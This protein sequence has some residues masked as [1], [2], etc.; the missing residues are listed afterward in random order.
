[1]GKS[2]YHLG[3]R[4]EAISLTTCRLT[5]TGGSISGDRTLCRHGPFNKRTFF[6]QVLPV[7]S[8][9]TRPHDIRQLKR[10][11]FNKPVPR[12]FNGSGCERSGKAENRSEHPTL[13][14]NSKRQHL[15]GCRLETHAAS[16]C[17]YPIARFASDGFSDRLV[18]R[19]VIEL[20]GQEPRCRR[21]SELYKRPKSR[22]RNEA[23]DGGDW[24]NW[25]RWR[26]AR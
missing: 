21:S 1:M 8:D 26:R 18:P 16:V 19:S 14:A 13:K 20:G 3:G 24:V 7:R 10:H 23:A 5:G 11:A 15:S 4:C 25:L 9:T 6:G 12:W 17:F 2:R 22:V